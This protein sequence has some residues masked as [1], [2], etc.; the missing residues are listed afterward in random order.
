MGFE[1]D[2]PWLVWPGPLL[3]VEQ[4]EG[5]FSTRQVGSSPQLSVDCRACDMGTRVPQDPRPRPDPG[6]QNSTGVGYFSQT[7]YNTL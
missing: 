1:G 4:G 6:R 2:H 7:Y 3:L 5:I